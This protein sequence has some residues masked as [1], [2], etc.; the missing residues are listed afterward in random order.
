[1]LTAITVIFGIIAY[2]L[3]FPWVAPCLDGF[4]DWA[5]D[6]TPLKWWHQYMNWVDDKQTQ[7]KITSDI[8]G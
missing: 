1:M 8:E 5:D 4:L 2:L 7:S 3:I 6:H